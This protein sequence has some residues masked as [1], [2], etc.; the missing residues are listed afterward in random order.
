MPA[1]IPQP[2]SVCPEHG[3]FRL[4]AT[5]RLTFPA[6]LR[7]EGAYLQ[8]ILEQR[9]GLRLEAGEKGELQL[10]MAPVAGGPEAY[11]L[12]V[13]GAGI[14]IEGK[15]P[16]AIFLGIQTLLQMLPA[17]GPA[18]RVHI[19]EARAIED[20]P[21]FGWRGLML[22]VGRHIFP[23][24]EIK[25]FLDLMAAYKFNRFHWHL[26]DD[27][28]WRIQIMKYP[29]LTEVGSIR[30]ETVIGHAGVHPNTFDG[31]PYGGFYTQ[32]EVREIVRH[33]AGL[34]I[35]VIPE[36]DMPGH[37]TAAIA[38]YPWLGSTRDALEVSTTW[39]VH[40]KG[41]LNVEEAAFQ[42]A[43]DVLDE[44]MAMFPGEF[45]HIG[46]DEAPK[47]MWRQDE[48]AQAVIRR[49]GLRDE[50]ELQS[51]FVRRVEKHL[52][53]RGRRLI[54]WDEILEGG[55]APNATVM[56]WRGEAGG[57]AAAKQ[58]HDAVMAPKQHVYFDYYQSEC[59]EQEPLA[60]GG[61]LPLAKVYAYEPLP[62]CLTPDESRHILGAQ[63]N[64]W[65]EYVPTMSHVQYMT[66]PRALALSEVCWSPRTRRNWDD[67][68][69]R[70]VAHLARLDA[71][72]INHWSGDMGNR[73][74]EH[75]RA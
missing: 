60:I 13:F 9:L 62:D 67:F 6:E 23:V 63:G 61:H 69:S 64:V 26:T 75:H 38:A 34:H 66:F 24:D 28:G 8:R 3:T 15:T 47:A 30:K 22:D 65:T 45:I 56:S 1:F 18:E 46:A 74:R 32:D 51:Y 72:G 2:V 19:L 68:L 37:C 73:E 40:E 57:I 54:G 25:G 10:G 12:A 59:R 17:A 39:G 70:V 71:W 35:D 14:R 5:T 55:L 20:E 27:Q 44:V 16:A 58:G 42:F 21:R 4:D 11:R 29:K 36:I 50:H 43:F 31:T 48:R 33:A 41:V 53:S 49:E 7:Q 52:N